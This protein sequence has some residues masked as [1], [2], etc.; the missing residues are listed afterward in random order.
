MATYAKISPIMVNPKDIA[1]ERRRRRRGKKKKT[2]PML[3]WLKTY[4]F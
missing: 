3:V 2:V 4:R 1:G